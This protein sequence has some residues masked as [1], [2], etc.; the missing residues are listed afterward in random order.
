VE[1]RTQSHRT[2]H[3]RPESNP[4][5]P[6]RTVDSERDA[7]NISP[8]PLPLEHIIAFRVFLSFSENAFDLSS[9]EFLNFAFKRNYRYP[10][11]LKSC[12]YEFRSLFIASLEV[13]KTIFKTCITYK[14]TIL[15]F[16]ITDKI[17]LFL[18]KSSNCITVISF[19]SELCNEIILMSSS[20]FDS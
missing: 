1:S 12:G 8:K 4:R 9:I 11:F 3:S 16:F 6:K 19:L 17:K 13:I 5:P 20:Y 15:L 10:K 14:L 18:S 2:P 7:V